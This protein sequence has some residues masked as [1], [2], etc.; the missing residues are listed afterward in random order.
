MI[1]LWLS[2]QNSMKP[3]IPMSSIVPSVVPLKIDS[4]Y[5][6][7]EPSVT[8]FKLVGGDGTYMFSLPSVISN[9]ECL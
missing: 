8:A 2:I 6:S 5:V 1:L 4:G 3:G 9:T 7:S